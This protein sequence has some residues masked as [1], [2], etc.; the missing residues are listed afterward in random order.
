MNDLVTDRLLLHPLTSA[1]AEQLVAH[2]PAQA[3]EYPTAMDVAGA[4]RHLEVYANTGDPQPFGAYEIRL[5]VDGRPIGGVGFHA[6]P[7]ERNTVTIGYGLS[8]AAR[9]NGYAAEALRGLLH[10]ARD[11]GII[12]VKG[13]TDRDNLA[14]Q[15]VMTAAGMHLVAEDHALKYYEITWAR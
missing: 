1:E 5:R 13:D 11:H 15:H 8:P 9:G 7:D 2:G 10:F 3:T 12:S 6:T 4:Q 14:S